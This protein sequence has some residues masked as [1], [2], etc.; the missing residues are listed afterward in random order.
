[1][2]SNLGAKDAERNTIGFSTEERYN[3]GDEATNSFFA[4]EFRN[5]LDGIIKFNK[6]GR[7]NMEQ[8]VKKFI[9]ELNDLVKNKNVTVD[10]SPDGMDLLVKR[11][12]NPKM[13]ARPLSRIID[14]EIKKPLSREML[15]GSLKNGGR[16]EVDVHN[17]DVI[18]SFRGLDESKDE[19]AD[20][21]PI[22]LPYISI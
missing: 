16:V 15:F 10:V 17:K 13:G 20:N 6:L 11:G 21:Q 2:T 4:P 7:S 12:F 1:M 18:L 8:I 22:I 5:R 14:Q 9:A 19:T 3:D